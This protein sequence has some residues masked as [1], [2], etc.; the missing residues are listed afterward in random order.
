MVTTITTVTVA[1]I[2]TI[3]TIVTIVS[4]G[5]CNSGDYNGTQCG[6]NGTLITIAITGKSIVVMTIVNQ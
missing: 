2:A 5:D 4:S 3:A 1:T 6:D